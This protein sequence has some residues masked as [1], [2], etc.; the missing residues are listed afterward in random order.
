AAWL[1]MWFVEPEA[2]R[3]GLGLALLAEAQ[4]R[5]DVLACIGFNETAARIFSGVG[6][7]VAPALSRWVRTVDV[8]AFEQLVG[9]P[10]I[11]SASPG[12][13]ARVVEWNEVAAGRWDDCW[14]MIVANI[15]CAARDEAFVR[16]RYAE[17]PVFRYIVRIAEGTGGDVRAL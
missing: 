15:I 17:H 9:R 16:R 6:F 14:K 10:P 4:R 8:A 12:P 3:D 13:S 5:F 1:A 7:D 2:R 11:G